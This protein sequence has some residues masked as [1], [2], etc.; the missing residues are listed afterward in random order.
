M[1]NAEMSAWIEKHRC[2]LPRLT[3]INTRL[4]ALEQ[5]IKWLRAKKETNEKQIRVSAQTLYKISRLCMKSKNPEKTLETIHSL[6]FEMCKELRN[7]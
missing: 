3:E 5:T 7:E 1:T 4:G 2:I 6:C